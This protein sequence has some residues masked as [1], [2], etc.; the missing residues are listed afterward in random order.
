MIKWKPISELGK[1][2]DRILLRKNNKYFIGSYSVNH[3]GITYDHA[4]VSG[5]LSSEEEALSKFDIRQD[6][7][8]CEGVSFAVVD[9]EK[10]NYQDLTNFPKDGRQ[11]IVNLDGLDVYAVAFFDKKTNKVMTWVDTIHRNKVVTCFY[12]SA[13]S[14]K[15]GVCEHVWADLPVKDS[16]F[17]V[18][19]DRGMH[20]P[21]RV[22]K[23]KK[24]VSLMPIAL[25][26]LGVTLALAG[27]LL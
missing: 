11:F 19:I 17:N 12:D 1:D 21:L 14:I 23:I 26:L 7:S 22:I 5:V 3:D 25:A 15:N 27:L 6:F 20:E 9:F 16:S 18:N 24:E 13:L 4:K 8:T 10:L 2:N